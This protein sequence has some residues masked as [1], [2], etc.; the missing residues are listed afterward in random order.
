MKFRL[1]LWIS[2][3]GPQLFLLIPY[4]NAVCW[5]HHDSICG[6]AYI[7][8]LS[9]VIAIVSG[10]LQGLFTVGMLFYLINI[11][12][13]D[14]DKLIYI[15]TF[16]LTYFII[17]IYNHRYNFLWLSAPIVGYIVW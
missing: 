16:C 13:N 4:Y 8:V 11:S 15:G 1:I 12:T 17:Y 9:I 7:Y 10:M 2:S 14:Q 5:G 6:V 3:L